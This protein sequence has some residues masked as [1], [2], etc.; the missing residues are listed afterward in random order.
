MEWLSKLLCKL[1]DE[2]LIALMALILLVVWLFY[3][4]LMAGLQSLSTHYQS[5]ERERVRVMDGLLNEMRRTNEL[6]AKQIT[7]LDTVVRHQEWCGRYR[8]REEK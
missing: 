5:Q 3:K 6:Q 8:A 7:L 2:H 1:S 4:L